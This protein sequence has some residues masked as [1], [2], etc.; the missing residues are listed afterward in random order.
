M[1]LTVLRGALADGGCG[2]GDVLNGAGGLYSRTTRPRLLVAAGPILLSPGHEAL[3]GRVNVCG[4]Q[5]SYSD[6]AGVQ[7]IMV[8][9]DKGVAQRRGVLEAGRDDS[10]REKYLIKDG[11][12]TNHR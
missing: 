8:V 7:Q 9:M 5:T 11:Y 2:G 12:K 10:C 6:C 4:V 1:A 3:T